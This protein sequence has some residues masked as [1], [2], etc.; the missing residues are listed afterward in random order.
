MYDFLI[1]LLGYILGSIPFSLLI[2]RLFGV[3]DLRKVGSG[4][5][6]A[7]NVMRTAGKFP[8]LIAALLDIGKGVAA[9]LLAAQF[10]G[11]FPEPARRHPARPG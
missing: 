11:H 5:T 8:A 3:P 7:T 1:I 10:G 4:N 9:V 2:A 6:G